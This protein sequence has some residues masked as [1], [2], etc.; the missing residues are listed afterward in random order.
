MLPMPRRKASY[1][2]NT[3][4]SISMCACILS[5]SL[6]MVRSFPRIA[7]Q[8]FANPVHQKSS[9]NIIGSRTVPHR[10]GR[11]RW[12]TAH[13]ATNT[14]EAKEELL[15]ME[16]IYREWTL[17][18][19][20]LLHNNIKLST[21]KLASLLGRGLRGVESRIKKLTNVEST[22]Y[23][24][25]F[26]GND[27]DVDQNDT[28][29]TSSDKSSKLTPVKE[30][31][32]RI[33][34]DPTLT[35]SS[36]SIVHYDRVED[37]LCETNFDA[38]NENIS[39]SEESFVFA[40][41]EHRI[42]RVKY[43]ERVVWDK[44][45]RLDCVFGTMKGRGE[46][47]DQVV[48]SYDEWK[49]EEDEREERNRFRQLEITNELTR[50]LGDNR[51]GELKTLSS[52]LVNNEWDADEVKDYVKHVLGLYYD[53]KREFYKKDD[54]GLSE[55]VKDFIDVVDFLYLFS[56]LVAL[57]PN[58]QL[59]EEILNEVELVV[60]RSQSESSDQSL[61]KSNQSSA[62][63]ELNDD[64]LEEKFVRGSG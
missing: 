37:K 20:R 33:K 15:T 14:D 8:A 40:L 36:F 2:M 25:L 57:L 47:I 51:V 29:N 9:W 59:R 21:V 18:D 61:S 6:P 34:W 54:C 53:T 10:S 64:E 45:M 52:T 1:S 19:D 4:T 16:N 39:G 28:I 38:S 30:V 5:T 41:P 42:Q 60:G 32:R 13:H 35:S 44:E 31:L 23:A 43:L 62:L 56:E 58:E 63:P 55:E 11:P 12:L 46:T 50:V 26:G 48:D 3:I 22:A 49:R 17:E 27:V 24:R 7:V